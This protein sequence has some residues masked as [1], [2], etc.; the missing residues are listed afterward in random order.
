M[1]KQI[2]NG[3][4]RELRNP[5]ICEK[6]CYEWSEISEEMMNSFVSSTGSIGYP[7]GKIKQN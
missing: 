1:D 3:K 7:C 4:N 6:E 5:H 2:A